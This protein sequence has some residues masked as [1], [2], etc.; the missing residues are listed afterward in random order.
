MGNQQVDLAWLAGVYD[1]EGCIWL[2]WVTR[3]K[4][5]K[6][7]IPHIHLSNTN[8]TLMNA[9]ANVLQRHGIPFHVSVQRRVRKSTHRPL[10]FVQTNGL[11]RAE[12][13]LTVLG[14]YLVGKR[15]EAVLLLEYIQSRLNAPHKAPYTEREQAIVEQL[16]QRKRQVHFRDLEPDGGFLGALEDI[17]QST[18]KLVE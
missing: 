1:G 11:K 9:A 12:K 6:Y 18:G 13:F 7:L 4:N 14:P 16:A 15:P 3:D 10:I 17:V 2:G 5:Y 8:A